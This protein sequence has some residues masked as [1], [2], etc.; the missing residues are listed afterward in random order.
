MLFGFLK[1]FKSQAKYP[2]INRRREERFEAEDEFVV[3]FNTSAKVSFHGQSRDI[4]VH[5]VRF[6]TSCKLS[7]GRKIDLNFVFPN[8]FPGA[9]EVRIP[10]TAVRVYR[11][12]GTER[13]RVACV[14]RHES[15]ITKEVLRQ[16]IH[17]LTHRA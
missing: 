16:F 1:K 10:A 13:Y 6:A 7:R 9:R 4:S 5:G 14:L 15:E 2:Q 8:R 12:R 17:W 3:K 11:P